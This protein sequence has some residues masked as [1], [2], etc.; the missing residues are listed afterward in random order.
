M[1]G[2]IEYL[3]ESSSTKSTKKNFKEFDRLCRLISKN[4]LKWGETAPKTLYKWVDDLTTLINLHNDDWRL[5]C[6]EQGYDPSS[7][8]HDFLA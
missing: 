7:N 5:Y 6:K 1:L 8:A 3:D 2:F 4:K